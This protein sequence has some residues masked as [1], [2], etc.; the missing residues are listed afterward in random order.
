MVQ[1][2]QSQPGLGSTVMHVHTYDGKAQIAVKD[3]GEPPEGLDQYS[4]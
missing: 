2:L 3:F 4:F 1:M